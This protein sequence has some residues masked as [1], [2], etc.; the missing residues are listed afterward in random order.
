MSICTTLQYS[1]VERTVLRSRGLTRLCHRRRRRALVHSATGRASGSNGSG[2]RLR[3]TPAGRL[4]RYNEIGQSAR[5][6]RP[7]AKVINCCILSTHSTLI[8]CVHQ[9]ASTSIIRID[10]CPALLQSCLEQPTSAPTDKSQCCSTSHC[11]CCFSRASLCLQWRSNLR[12]RADDEKAS[13]ASVRS[14]SVFEFDAAVISYN[15]NSCDQI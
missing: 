14:A 8:N 15:N 2:Q 13:M 7:L 10:N 4:R 3:P 9:P 6:R 11:I 1:P 5:G 12:E